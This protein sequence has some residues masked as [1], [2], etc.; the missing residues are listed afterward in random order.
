M[1]RNFYSRIISSFLKFSY[2]RDGWV[3]IAVISS[4]EFMTLHIHYKCLLFTTYN[5]EE[6][7]YWE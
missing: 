4:T 3:K 1:N 5:N 7:I 6:N 2:I